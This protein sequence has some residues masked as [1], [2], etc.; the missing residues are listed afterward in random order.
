VSTNFFSVKEILYLKK[1][2]IVVDKGKFYLHIVKISH[3]ISFFD[4][5]SMHAASGDKERL[6]FP[7]TANREK[8]D[9]K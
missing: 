9:G 4:Y 1:F 3:R 5:R 2:F 7:P 8:C 6:A